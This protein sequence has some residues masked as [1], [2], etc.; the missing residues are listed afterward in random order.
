MWF[1]IGSMVVASIAI[2]FILTSFRDQ[3]VFFYTPSQWQEKIASGTADPTRAVSIGGLVEKESVHHEKN[4]GLR[5][6]I[7]DHSQRIAVTYHGTLPALFREGQGVV[8]QGVIRNGT[9]EA[10]TI[11]AKHDE[12]YMPRAVVEQLKKSGR[13]QEGQK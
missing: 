8:A 11:L 13:W 9:L 2:S 1:V 7:T 4:N 3:L 5:F 6:V 12:N 10:T